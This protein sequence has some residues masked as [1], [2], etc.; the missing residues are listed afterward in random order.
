MPVSEPRWLGP[1]ETRAWRGYQIMSAQLS[2]RLH[3]SLVEETGLS[4]SDYVVLVHLS[5][6]PENTLRPY[7]LG[8]ALT[9]EKSRL[10]H[11]LTRMER[12]GLIC[13]RE[14]ETDAR[15][16]LVQL[17]EA[18]RTAIESAAPHHVEHVRNLMI[19][20]LTPSELES[21]AE[22]SEKLLERMSGD[23]G[24]CDAD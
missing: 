17:T 7:E 12:R 3:R 11:H 16:Q 22:I 9:W 4:L 6:A 21:I 23:C 19:D 14:C 10:S 18:G 1:E 15:G 2:A 13:R 5:E 20:H 24:A 8:S